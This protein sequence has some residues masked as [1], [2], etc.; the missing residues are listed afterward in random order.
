VISRQTLLLLGIVLTG[1]GGEG[2]RTP[3]TNET[4][5]A[6]TNPGGADTSTGPSTST[7]PDAPAAGAATNG[8]A[9]TNGLGPGDYDL[10]ITSGG[11]ER[12]AHVHVPASYDPKKPTPVLLNFHGRLSNP[13]QQELVSKTTPKADAAGF[14]VVYPAGVGQTWNAGLCC[15]EAQSENVDDVG[16]TRALLD[17]LG[18]KLCVDGKRVFATGLSNGGFMSNRLA[19]ELS[20]R[21]AAIGPVAGQL[22]MTTCT[23]KRAVPVMYFHGDADTIV[24]YDGKYGMPSAEESAKAWAT[25]NACDATPKQTYAKGDTT[26]MTYSGCKDS[27][28]VT[29]CTISGGGHTWPGGTPI[30][31]LG[32]TSTDIDATSEMWTFFAAHPMP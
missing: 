3:T 21:I 23:P 30:P 22:M 11:R 27:A 29:L 24:A 7:P 28:D 12:T 4:P 5:G 6:N 18:A 10:T 20:D 25:R 14:V 8:C 17:E 32:K 1:C 15:G 9:T 2:A 26:C 19:C 31:G 16:F 13:S